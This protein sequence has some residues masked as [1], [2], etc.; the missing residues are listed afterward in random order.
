M[1]M[2]PTA[3]RLISSGQVVSMP[4]LLDDP[5]PMPPGQCLAAQRC[6]STTQLHEP[7]RGSQLAFLKVGKSD[8]VAPPPAPSPAPGVETAAWSHVFPAQNRP[9][10]GIGRAHTH[11]PVPA[12][13]QPKQAVAFEGLQ[14]LRQRCGQQRAPLSARGGAAREGVW[15]ACQPIATI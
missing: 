5:W 10:R 14:P 4:C 6:G 11:H 7:S 9:L 1:V 12:C 3:D 2:Q 13:T 8:Q 15:A